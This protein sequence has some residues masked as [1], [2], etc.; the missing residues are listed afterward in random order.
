MRL[1]SE[2]V[3][4]LV[5]IYVFNVFDDID[6]KLNK[7]KNEEKINYDNNNRT[8]SLRAYEIQRITYKNIK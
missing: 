7:N 1:I 3:K 4:Y 5:A 8:N 2:H 6:Y